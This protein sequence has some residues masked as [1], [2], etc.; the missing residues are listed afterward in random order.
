MQLIDDVKRI[1]SNVQIPRFSNIQFI[2]DSYGTCWFI[3]VN[4]RFSGA[5]ATTMSVVND[6]LQKFKQSLSGDYKFNINENVKWNSIVTRYYEEVV[7]EKG[8]R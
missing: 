1:L 7:Y 2:K 6:Y 3:E 4:Y 8:T 5:G